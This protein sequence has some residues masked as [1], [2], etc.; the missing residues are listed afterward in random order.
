MKTALITWASWFV[1]Y[2]T[3]KRLLELGYLVIGI[4]EENNY[5]DSALKQARRKQLIVMDNYVFYKCNIN[6]TTKIR[7]VFN[8]YKPKLVIHLAAQAW[9]RHSISHPQEYIDTNIVGFHNIISLANEFNVEK[10]IYAS[11]SSV[12]GSHGDSIAKVSDSTNNPLSI[13]AASKKANELIAHVYSHLYNLTTIGFRFFTVYWPRW[14][15]D[16]A[17]YKFTKSILEEREIELF[18][19]GKMQRDFTYIDDIINGLVAWITSDKD[20]YQIYNL[21]CA[22]PTTLLDL[23]DT[24]ERETW[25]KA[26]I[27][28]VQKEIADPTST[29]ADIIETQKQI[30]WLPTTSINDWVKKFVEW[31]KNYSL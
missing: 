4:D 8:N 16:M 20:W 12:Y 22:S 29:F 19:Y 9:V 10:F 24:I 6:E 26:K 25:K 5:Y 7:Q 1:W 18:N 3:A 2:H 14:R 27:N 21:G 23:V 15:P 17:I 31:Y 28:L 30:N 11:S 13:Y